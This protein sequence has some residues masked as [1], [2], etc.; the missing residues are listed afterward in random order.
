MGSECFWRSWLTGDW[1]I[2]ASSAVE[3][4]RALMR[5]NSCLLQCPYK[6]NQFDDELLL[7]YS[8]TAAT[9]YGSYALSRPISEGHGHMCTVVSCPQ[10][11]PVLSS[12]THA[13]AW[14]TREA[15]RAMARAA[16]TQTTPDFKLP[17]ASPPDAV[18]SLASLQ[19][20]V[21]GARNYTYK[22][23]NGRG[24]VEPPPAL[25]DSYWQTPR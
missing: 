1:G 9:K 22:Y 8:F 24:V 19:L 6:G 15:W 5:E 11:T 10:E 17:L 21:Q 20:K 7:A 14:P 13:G 12:A 23:E 3:S 16:F 2:E 25:C 18:P 4:P